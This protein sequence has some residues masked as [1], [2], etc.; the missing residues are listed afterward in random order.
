MGASYPVWPL[1]SF[2]SRHHDELHSGRPPPGRGSHPHAVVCRSVDAARAHLSPS[3]ITGETSHDLHETVLTL[4]AR[5]RGRGLPPPP[6]DA[7]LCFTKRHRATI[8]LEV[9]CLRGGLVPLQRGP[10]GGDSSAI[11]SNGT[12]S[13]S[14]ACLPP[15]P[16]RWDRREAEVQSLL[17]Q[18]A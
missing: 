11:D 6:R 1:Q 3:N 18:P 5:G 12:L 7:G 15:P 16:L 10:C 17:Q 9:Q 13:G 4:E 14:G 8:V 2:P